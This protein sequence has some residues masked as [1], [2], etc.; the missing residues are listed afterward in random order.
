MAVAGLLALAVPEPV[1][2]ADAEPRFVVSED[3]QEVFDRKA[4]LVWRRCVEGLKWT[5]KTCWGLPSELE[6]SQAQALA[7][8]TAKATGQRWRL[9]HATE[10]KL[11]LAPPADSAAGRKPRSPWID[12]LAFPGTPPEWHWSASVN[13][14][15][16]NINPYNYGNIAQGRTGSNVNQVSF[17]HA[18]AV[19]FGTGEARGEVPKRHPMVVRLVRPPS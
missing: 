4:R 9:P 11:L 14:G 12:E 18:W 16:G 8:D 19:H 10:L 6:H 13:V 5:G 17:L 1:R 2:A 3:G 15:G 7:Q